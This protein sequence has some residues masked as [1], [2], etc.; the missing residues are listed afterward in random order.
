[1]TFCNLF[2]YFSA[3][4]CPKCFKFCCIGNKL[5]EL[6]AIYHIRVKPNDY[7]QILI[8]DLNT[9]ED[10]SDI[11]DNLR[12]LRCI[13]FFTCSDPCARMDSKIVKHAL[14]VLEKNASDEKDEYE[15][16]QLHK[17]MTKIE[18]TLETILDRL[19]DLTKK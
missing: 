18:T 1:M 3:S 17:R 7:N 9:Q 19:N 2:L 6:K 10:A 13:H 14:Q 16:E 11:S 5:E 4:S 12:P 15:R 8:P